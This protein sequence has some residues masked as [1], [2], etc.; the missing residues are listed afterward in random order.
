[1]SR[2]C[3]GYLCSIPA[4]V[5]IFLIY[6]VLLAQKGLEDSEGLIYGRGTLE[7]P[8]EFPQCLGALLHDGR[9][10]SEVYRMTNNK[11]IGV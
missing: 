8:R 5:R 11:Y 4:Q 9:L 1:M 2:S 10:D 7:V 6:P 3:G